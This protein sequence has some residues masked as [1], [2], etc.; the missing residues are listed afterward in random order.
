MNSSTLNLECAGCKQEIHGG[1]ALIAL[2]QQWHTWCFTC[3]RCGKQLS[4]EYLGR[5]ES[6]DSLYYC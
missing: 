4:G 5:Y 3:N 2:E 1:Q 6:W